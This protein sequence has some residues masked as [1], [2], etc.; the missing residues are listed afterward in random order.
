MPATLHTQCE[1]A[2][3]AQISEEYNAWYTYTALA[4]YFRQNDVG[5]LGVADVMQSRANDE[6]S[7]AVKFSEYLAM[8]GGQVQLYNISLGDNMG[9][10]T[11][12][13]PQF[14]ILEGFVLALKLEQHVYDRLMD[15][16]N[17]AQSHNDVQLTDY[18][19]SEFL[20]EQVKDIYWFECEIAKLKRM[21]GDGHGRIA[22][23]CNIKTA[24]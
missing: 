24:A 6:H 14:D 8:R 7:H 12:I 4:N 21:R 19:E 11:T 15:L 23:D 9:G 1:A 16:H 10:V 2:L 3:N 13:D 20:D 18:I 22:Y 5:L 17:T